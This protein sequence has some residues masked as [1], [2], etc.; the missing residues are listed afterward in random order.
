MKTTPDDAADLRPDE[1]RGLV[2]ATLAAA[3]GEGGGDGEGGGEGERVDDATLIE[4][5]RALVAGDGA[6][7]LWSVGL[8][9][10]AFYRWD[11]S[12]WTPDEPSGR[13]L[14]VTPA[15]GP[16]A[17]A[18]SRTCPACGTPARDDE[19]RFCVR[20]RSELPAVHPDACARCGATLRPGVRF[21]TGCGA[22]V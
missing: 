6:G 20:C 9:T 5:A 1:L 19:A 13:L 14:L 22:P 15:E 17:S 21:C 2:R 8:A 12:R 4:V 3:R 7:R 10:G 11:G 18:A 16:R